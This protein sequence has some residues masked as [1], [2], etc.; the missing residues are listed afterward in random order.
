MG[1]SKAQQNG[2]S[3][4]LILTLC[5]L[6]A[7]KHLQYRP[8]GEIKTPG[9]QGTQDRSHAGNIILMQISAQ[10]IDTKASLT[11]LCLVCFQFV[12]P[13]IRVT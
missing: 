11:A 6:S 2:G 3:Q 8:A 5:L 9:N 4:P 12:W 7:H 13:A 10:A 1:S